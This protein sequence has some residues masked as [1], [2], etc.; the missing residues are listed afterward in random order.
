[1]RAI[2]VV[3]AFAVLFPFLVGCDK[4][5][6]KKADDDKASTSQAQLTLS[7]ED[8][9]HLGIET[10]PVK[11]A[12]YTPNVR[13]YGSVV[14]FDVLAQ[15]VSDVTI[16]QA[17]ALQSQ[18]A[19]AH[20][21][22]L[23][24]EQLITRDALA[25]AERQA[26]T[27]AAAV[28]LAERKQ[29]VSFGRNAPWRSK[30]DSDAILSQLA[31]GHMVLIRVSF[32]SSVPSQNVPEKL[33]VERVQ[34]GPGGGAWTSSKVWQAP[35]DPNLPGWGFFALVAN[36]DLAEGERVLV[37]MPVGQPISGELIPANAVLLSGDK[38]WCYTQSKPGG[39]VRHPL[40]ISRPINDGYFVTDGIKAGQAVVV[41]GG[42]LLLAHELNPSSG[43]KD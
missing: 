43:D 28:L 8:V 16:A 30:A 21:R 13:G 2:R 40:D 15:S 25:I 19:F 10:A 37:S 32:P 17:A 14:S 5:A 9:E 42:A 29:V 39:Y 41:Q 1:M 20:A 18:A 38:A 3:L 24:A 31:S 35:A 23:A 22:V 6:E 7:R 33:T 36:T 34:N 27:D 26:T 4:Q 12:Q 11:T